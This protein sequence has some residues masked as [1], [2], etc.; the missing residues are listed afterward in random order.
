MQAP[1]WS[2]AANVGHFAPNGKSLMVPV[3]STVSGIALIQVA[4]AEPGSLLPAYLPILRDD[5]VHAS[6]GAAD[7]RGKDVM[8]ISSVGHR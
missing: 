5:L 6:I 2:D 7:V 1:R 4:G 3:G 8:V